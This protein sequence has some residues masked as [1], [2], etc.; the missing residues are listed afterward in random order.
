M[1]KTVSGVERDLSLA[2]KLGVREILSWAADSIDGCVNKKDLEQA[3]RSL[4]DRR[5][6]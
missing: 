2:G 5:M 4:A 3:M 6:E 1:P